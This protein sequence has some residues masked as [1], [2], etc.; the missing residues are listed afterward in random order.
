MSSRSQKVGQRLCCST[1]PGLQPQLWI[2]TSWMMGGG[3]INLGS[4]W[5][6]WWVG[7]CWVVCVFVCWW[8]VVRLPKKCLERPSPTPVYP[9][10]VIPP[11]GPTGRLL[12]VGIIGD[13]AFRGHNVNCRAPV[14][15]NRVSA[16]GSITVYGKW[17]SHNW[18]WHKQA[19]CT[20]LWQHLSQSERSSDSD[21]T[22]CAHTNNIN[23]VQPN[24][25]RRH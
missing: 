23:V 22:Q 11:P 20:W 10:S 25:W 13:G 24:W 7:G 5:W 2:L 3:L 1:L 19:V 18:M 14:V 8:G 9:I 21:P 17:R 16:P 15:L 6:G 4:N 12:L